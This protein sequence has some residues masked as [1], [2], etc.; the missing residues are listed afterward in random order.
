MRTLLAA[1]AFA[2]GGA[3]AAPPPGHYSPAEIARG[4]YLAI[5]GDCTAC[6]TAPGR[7]EFSG[8][9]A[10]ESPVGPIVATNITPSPRF[11]IGRY[12]QA[13]F[14]AALRRGIRSDG[15]HLYPA[16]PYTSYALLSDEDVR[17][18]YAYFMAGVEPVDLAVPATQLPFPFGVRAT[19]ATWNALFLHEQRFAEAPGRGAVWNRGAYLTQALGHCSACHTPRGLLMQEDEARALGGAPF[20]PWYAPNI[21][22][23]TRSGIGDWSSADLIDYLGTGVAPGK[24]RAAGGMAEVVEHS[25]SRMTLEDLRAIA[26]YLKTVP[27]ARAAA[28]DR[29]VQALAAPVQGEAGL[30]GATDKVG[31]GAALYSGLCASCHGEGG[32]GTRDKAYPDLDPAARA[33]ADRKANLIAVI[34]NGVDR[35]VGGS[36]VLMPA[37]GSTSYVQALSDDEVA[38]VASYVRSRFGTGGVV[39]AAEVATARA[40]GPRSRLLALFYAF[41]LM[42]LLVP[43]GAIAFWLRRKA[44]R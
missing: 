6:H 21:T 38:A 27:P 22:S 12:S 42:L 34:L 44:Q 10:I 3:A 5:A 26:V 16:M 43:M 2:V 15:A 9:P 7:P 28:P 29:P 17:A 11:G 23:D 39:T 1:L 8:G 32:R 13:Q 40:G 37:F 4:R 19:M 41:M 14:A 30:R 35:T 31:P 25:L 20:G 24:G 36:H 33:G 18:L